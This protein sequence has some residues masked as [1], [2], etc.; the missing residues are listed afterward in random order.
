MPGGEE[1][2]ELEDREI[3]GQDTEKEGG[4]QEEKV[5]KETAVQS[6]QK[7]SNQTVVKSSEDE[8]DKADEEGEGSGN[9]SSGSGGNDT[10]NNSNINSTPTSETPQNNTLAPGTPQSGS[11]Q[12][13]SQDETG[14]DL[15]AD[16]V[17][18]DV[19][20]TFSQSNGENSGGSGDQGEGNG[21]FDTLE[22]VR[23]LASGNQESNQQT[24][25]TGQGADKL[26]K[27]KNDI[28]KIRTG[29]LYKAVILARM[30]EKGGKNPAKKVDNHPR[31]TRFLNSSR[32]NKASDINTLV[33]AG[34]GIAS[35]FD[36]NY[37]NSFV[38]KG[39]TLVTSMLAMISSIRNIIKKIRNWK[40]LTSK[41]DKAFTG[42]SLISDFSTVVSKAAMIAKTIAGLVGAS[43]GIFAKV[44]SYVSTITG[45]LSQI[46]GLLGISRTVGEQAADIT[47]L[48]KRRATYT[49]IVDDIIGNHKNDK[50]EEN[51]SGQNDENAV[52]ADTESGTP[53]E[54][55]QGTPPPTT[56][57]N[58]ETPPHPEIPEEGSKRR[59]L[60]QAGTRK[61]PGAENKARREKVSELLK[62]NK[63]SK[64]EKD[65]LLSYWGIS[66]RIKR[67]KTDLINAVN[68]GIGL[69][70]GMATT[71]LTGVSIE[72]E[73]AEGP[74]KIASTVSN[75]WTLLTT[76]KK[77][78]D[79][80][81]D[82][83][84]HNKNAEETQMMQDKLWGIMKTLGQDKYGLKG[85]AKS[86]E[87]QSGAE[88][89][90][91]AEGLVTKYKRVD[92]QFDMLG[93]NYGALMQAEDE[94][95]FKQLLVEGL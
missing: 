20:I 29:G 24:D 70:M 35:N 49:K 79:K 88:K 28:Q 2:K 94:K 60:S 15:K 17:R 16:R 14:Q 61:L 11:P 36:E 45:G 78:V 6:L 43:K 46:A 69:V 66:R 21:T 37:K 38:G 9:N 74:T 31:L 83:K 10:L 82:K 4:N 1:V 92:A 18:G 44:M 5:I 93:V 86:L 8:E 12:I 89:Q 52:L 40:G 73:N 77:F 32:L 26:K 85:V 59:R 91:F 25:S 39:V 51:V 62:S 90:N 71:I 84:D 57:G 50:N 22:E 41:L 56:G 64:D 42:I 72:D 65:R 63:I 34:S 47:L 27:V 81:L 87:G 80:T 53:T 58:H 23:N 95:K 30:L 55:R 75:S 48:R 68:S 54:T 7:G 3:D 76:G 19:A 33:A 67:K 13:P